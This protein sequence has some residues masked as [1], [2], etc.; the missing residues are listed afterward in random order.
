MFTKQQFRID[1]FPPGRTGRVRLSGKNKAEF[2]F[3]C[4]RNVVILNN[5]I[6]SPKGI[7]ISLIE[8]II[9]ID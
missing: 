4:G 8:E 2:E 7:F 6:S 1:D 9:E 5:H 3:C